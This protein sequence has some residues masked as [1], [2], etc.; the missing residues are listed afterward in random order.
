MIA[1][2]GAVEGGRVVE[3]RRPAVEDRIELVMDELLLARVAAEEVERERQRGGRRLMPGE[4]ED[5]RLV[6]HLLDVHR[7]AGVR[8]AGGSNR[9]RRSSPSAPA[10]CRCA[11]SSS[12][13][14]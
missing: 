2:A 8:I 14:S 3:R 6:A 11:I 5:Q 1:I 12:T 9:E 10:C 13:T 4:Q 7:F